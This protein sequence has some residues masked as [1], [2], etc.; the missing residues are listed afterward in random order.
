M[1][2]CFLVF[3]ACCFLYSNNSLAMEGR[4]A[5][6]SIYNSN[7]VDFEKSCYSYLSDIL[8]HQ[9][10]SNSKTGSPIVKSFEFR[11]KMRIYSDIEVEIRCH[12]YF[13]TYKVDFNIWYY[14]SPDFNKIMSKITV[15]T[16]SNNELQLID[17]SRLLTDNI[18]IFI[19]QKLKRFCC[20][21]IY[22][23]SEPQTRP[24]RKR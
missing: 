3:V 14:E 16:S 23:Y 2:R 19:E 4:A 6:I 5:S 10:V 11:R 18:V 13:G 9:I 8:I 22:Y 7:N 1:R 15:S 12:K 17:F 21:K 24:S 20:D